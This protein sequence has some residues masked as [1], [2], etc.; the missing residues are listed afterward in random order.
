[1]GPQEFLRRVAKAQPGPAYFFPGPELHQ[2]QRA[3]EALVAHVPPGVRD[4]NL[5][6][7][8]GGEADLAEVAGAARTVPFAA[9]RR[10]VILR[11]LDRFKLSDRRLDLL[12]EYLKAPPPE[13]TF[14]ATTEDADAAKGFR[15]RFGALW[16][17]VAFA[18]LGSRQLEAEVLREVQRLGCRVAP[19]AVGAL[20]EATGEDLGRVLSELEKLRSAVGEGGLIGEAEVLLHVGGYVHKTQFDLVTRI[21]ARDLPGSLR[22]LAQLVVKP[23]DAL[24]LM[25]L[26]GKRLRMLL[27]LAAGARQLPR[28][29]N[30]FPSQETALRQDARRFTREELERGLAALLR[31]DAAIKTTALPPRLL[32][33][34]FL[35]G[36]LG[37]G[38]REPAPRGG[39]G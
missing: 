17:E 21:S 29:F 3:L 20:L 18:P 34:S 38:T 39:R 24:F 26:I 1:V 30:A 13:T 27:C 5:N 36:L 37:P 35:V 4:F 22:L 6:V 11:D 16:E 10:L 14:V 32:L 23:E 12:E 9:P 25:G 28:V 31:V 8:H 2:K 7:F 33:E 15:K 19:G